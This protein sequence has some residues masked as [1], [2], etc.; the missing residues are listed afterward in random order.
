MTLQGGDNGYPEGDELTV[1][2][3]EGSAIGPGELVY[4]TGH[5]GD[6]TEVQL[7]DDTTGYDAV[8]AADAG[9]ADDGELLKA[10]F[11]GTPWVRVVDADDVSPGDEVAGSSTSG[12]ATNAA[13]G[14][15]GNGDTYLQGETQLSDGN[16][17][18]LAHIN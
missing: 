12:S 8:A 13:T 9:G 17:Y 1:K 18:A 15:A 6:H 10:T 4:V 14:G 5:D 3:A 2:N 11:R 16:T 7:A